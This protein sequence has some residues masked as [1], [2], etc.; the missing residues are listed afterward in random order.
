MKSAGHSTRTARGTVREREKYNDH[1]NWYR[2][3]L[4][5]GAGHVLPDRC[6]D[7]RSMLR[8]Y[9]DSTM[10]LCGTACC[11]ERDLV[12]INRPVLLPYVFYVLC[13]PSKPSI[14]STPND[15]PSFN[16]PKHSLEPSYYFSPFVVAVAAAGK[17]LEKKTQ[18]DKGKP[19][20]RTI[21]QPTHPLHPTPTHPATS[22]TA[23]VLFTTAIR[24]RCTVCTPF[25]FVSLPHLTSPYLTSR[26]R[27]T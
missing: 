22:S 26:Q 11:T 20:Y 8:A 14:P 19:A 3:E 17:P 18:Q 23:T 12:L 13:R 4:R 25:V 24:Q 9:F 27:A 10:V 5:A 21:H 15:N 16:Q 6:I 2:A 7:H 1:R